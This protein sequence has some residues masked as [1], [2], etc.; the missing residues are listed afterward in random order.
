VRGAP[1]SFNDHFSQ[2]ALFYRSLTP[3]EQSH[4]VEAFTFELG[5][6][7][8]QEIKERELA[9]LANV[10]AD[11]CAR[12]A[13]GLGLP[14]PQGAPAADVAASPALSQVVEVPGPIDGR[15]IGVLAGPDAD[16]PGI[17]KLRRAMTKLGAALLVVAP[18]GGTLDDGVEALT[19]DRTLLATRSIEFDAFVIA[20]GAP[21]INDV[22]LTV[23]LQET[24]RHYK[25]LGAWGSGSAVLAAAGLPHDAPGIVTATTVGKA[26]NE[27]LAASIGIHRVWARAEM[28]RTSPALDE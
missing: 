5:K 3:I 13:A 1:T 8:E 28:V 19:V 18:V 23:L 17:A 16:L 24:F 25:A 27:Q 14:A 12:V 11:L 15:K 20:D 7:F 21:P 22:R 2:A 4:V 6:V 10:D 9:V 26:F